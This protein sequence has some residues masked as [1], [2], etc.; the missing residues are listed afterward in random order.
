MKTR[1]IV[2]NFTLESVL[3]LR[4]VRRVT[5]WFIGS[6]VLLIACAHAV[7]GDLDTSFGTGG[8]VISRSGFS[9]SL[10]EEVNDAVLQRDGK[11]VMIGVCRQPMLPSSF[12]CISRHTAAGAIDTSFG[13]SNT[14]FVD[15]RFAG[16]LQLQPIESVATAVA[17]QRDGKIVVA[18]YCGPSTLSSVGSGYLEICLIRLLPTG[19]LDT[20]FGISGAVLLQTPGKGEAVYAVNIDGNGRI[21]LGGSIST[22]T[23]ANTTVG[24]VA[25]LLGNGQPDT[26]FA[27]LGVKTFGDTVSGDEVIRSLAPKFD[28]DS[29]YFAFVGD[30][31]LASD[32]DF[33][34]GTTSPFGQNPYS[35]PIGIVDDYARKVVALPNFGY[36]LMGHCKLGSNFGFCAARTSQNIF[37][38]PTFGTGGK[39]LF[40]TF[41]TG[42]SFARTGLAQPDGKLV[43][44][45]DCVNGSISKLCLARLNLDGSL[46]RTFGVGGA[47]NVVAAIGTGDM[48][49]KLMLQPDGKLL[50]AGTCLSGV[51]SF[52]ITRFEGGPQPGRYCSL[53]V[54]GDGQVLATTDLLIVNRINSGMSGPEVLQGINLTGKPRSTWSAIRSY[55]A[56]QCGMQ[57]AR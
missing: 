52:C 53:D 2:A 29:S 15:Y 23:P 31:T 42:D 12:F 39:V 51:Q 37:L 45:G 57:T 41:G 35:L 40:P 19:A 5:A 50:L 27:A 32:A 48:G 7:P 21:L 56:A 10:N 26:S 54:D 38:D 44:A 17:L 11:I 20:T 22:T 4:G 9:P 55:L 6:F 16:T 8:R 34:L 28:L 46:D 3:R 36:A 24:F 1:S 14:G 33:Y 49:V 47:G 13:P 43:L 25:R 18:G 30:R